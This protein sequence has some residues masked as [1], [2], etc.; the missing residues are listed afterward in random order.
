MSSLFRKV[1]ATL[2]GLTLL[3]FAARASAAAPEAPKANA[4]GLIVDLYTIGPAASFPTRFGH[5]LLCVRE[6]DAGDATCYDYG[7]PDRSELVHMGWTASRGIPSFVPVKVS[8]NFALGFF[9]SQQRQIERQRLPLGEDEAK[10]L[11]AALDDDVASGR[12]YAYHPYWANCATKLRDHL[13]A[14]TNGRLRPGPASIPTGTFREYSEEG[15]SGRIELLTP[16][17]LFLGEESDRTPTPWEAMFLPALLRDGVA[18]RFGVPPEKIAERIQ[19][20]VPTSRAVGRIVIAFV[21]LV[22]FALIRIA[23]R[24]RRL[25]RALQIAGFVLGGTAVLVDMVSA[26]VVWPEVS[27]NWALALLLPTDL[28][29]LFP[30]VV[31]RSPRVLS[32]YLKVRLGMAAAAA[33]LEI[34]GVAHQ[35]LLPLALF[36]ALPL[37][38]LLTA[39]RD[40]SVERVGEPPSEGVEASI[41]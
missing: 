41:G 23:A 29:L 26:L 17:A 3:G 39:L 13:D 8:E 28:A 15:N 40:S 24:R 12:A 4:P 7:V 30:S 21:A 37:A 34:A 20:T 10:K 5:S 36:V 27:H 25:D 18:D 32:G 6:G 31:A 11:A 16:M 19:A 22:V 33:V 38:G 1:L 2:I 14:A 9:R 35:P